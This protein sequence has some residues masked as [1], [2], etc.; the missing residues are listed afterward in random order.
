MS[1][2]HSIFADGGG[3]GLMPTQEKKNCI[4][5]FITR[6][7]LDNN[8]NK[9]EL[10]DSK[11]KLKVVKKNLK[12]LTSD[13]QK[14]RKRCAKKKQM[15]AESADKSPTNAAKLQKLINKSPRL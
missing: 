11:N 12:N 10:E 6:F 3:G 15:I 4:I 2:P 9:K 13:S 1:L 14:Q 8:E 5:N 7:W